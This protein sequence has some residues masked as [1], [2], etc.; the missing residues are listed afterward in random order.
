MKYS[1]NLK[2]IITHIKP[3]RFKVSIRAM[4]AEKFSA[5]NLPTPENMHRVKQQVKKRVRSR[6]VFYYAPSFI[7]TFI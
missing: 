2:R 7:Y 1:R 4:P 6:F 5:R 3:D